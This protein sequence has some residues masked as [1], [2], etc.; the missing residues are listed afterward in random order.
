MMTG[1][2]HIEQ[3]FEQFRRRVADCRGADPFRAEQVQDAY[4]AISRLRERYLHE[5]D[6]LTPSQRLALQKVFDKD[7]FIKG[8]CEIRQVSEH[9]TRQEFRVVTPDKASFV[10]ETSAHAMFEGTL[11]VLTDAQT[12]Q[13]FQF[14]HQKQLDEAERRIESAL[15]KARQE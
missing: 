7:W 13:L 9:I 11:V 6:R 14:D 5:Q 4:N 1:L 10:V 8:V 3:D 2:E 15:E 12:G